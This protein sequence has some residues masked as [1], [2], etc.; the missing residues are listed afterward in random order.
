MQ[1]IP[2]W[3]CI[4]VAAKGTLLELKQKRKKEKKKKAT[5]NGENKEQ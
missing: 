2:N 5:K 4:T 3:T 1:H